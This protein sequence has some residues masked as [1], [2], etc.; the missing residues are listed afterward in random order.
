MFFFFL[1]VIPEK[2]NFKFYQILHSL[3]HDKIKFK[4]LGNL[5]N[6][7]KLIVCAIQFLQIFKQI[8]K[9]LMN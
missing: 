2:S 5:L 7:R 4:I 9:S 6:N 8:L 3:C 1:I